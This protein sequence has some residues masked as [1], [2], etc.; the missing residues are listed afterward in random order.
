MPDS[1]YDSDEDEGENEIVTGKYNVSEGE[2]LAYN[3]GAFFWDTIL[4]PYAK[5]TSPIFSVLQT[6]DVADDN[7]S[8]SSPIIEE[9][10]DLQGMTEFVA[11]IINNRP[12][13]VAA[14]LTVDKA[15]DP[16]G[17]YTGE[18]R[19]LP[20]NGTQADLASTITHELYHALGRFSSASEVEDEDGN[21]FFA[22]SETLSKW[23]EHL[24]DTKGIKA[25]PE[26][27]IMVENRDICEDA[28]GCFVTANSAQWSGVYFS[29]SNVG[30]VLNGAK[31]LAPSE[32]ESVDP[33]SVDRR[34]AGIPINTWEYTG[35]EYRLDLSHIELRNSLQSHL[36]YRNWNTFMEAELAIL[37]DLGYT[38]DRRNF[39]GYSVY[40][41]NFETRSFIN[42]NPFYARLNG[43][44]L[45]GVPNT[46]PWGIGLH[47]YGSL[48]DVTQKANLLADGNFS[49]GIRVDGWENA[50]TIDSDTLVTAN[51]DYG[52]GVLFSYGKGH[53]LDVKGTV[54]AIGK[55]GIALAFDFGDNEL[56]S[57]IE[58]RGSYIR[59]NKLS[60][61]WKQMKLFAELN[62]S[63]MEEINVSGTVSG[64][65][66][67]V[68]IGSTAHVAQINILS[69]ASVTGDII[70]DWNPNSELLADSAPDDL[71]TTLT[72]GTDGNGGAAEDFNDDV[73]KYQRYG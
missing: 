33:E 27:T 66:A 68:Y 56:G 45:E 17:W 4:G 7:A 10:G 9:E 16:N 65:L 57:L 67:A 46:T 25:R 60:S 29:G 15:I 30:K 70:S 52:Y 23:D 71:F 5:N 41:D 20:K 49:A 44:F 40:H 59:V 36:S 61:D 19:L 31:L 63:L 69:G 21:K 72:F 14:F 51:G 73:G 62:G 37:Q 6:I 42:E 47:I 50:L 1:Y 12:S 18:M 8:A 11:A 53:N 58:T 3:T 64:R 28:E 26:Q 13:K 32:S 55:D 34:Y 54:E 39:F 35:E 2:L 43:E 38:I 22:F 48:N 24:Y